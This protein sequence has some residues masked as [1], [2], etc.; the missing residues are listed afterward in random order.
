M[1]RSNIILVTLKQQH[2]IMKSAISIDIT[3]D[4]VLAIVKSLPAR[5]KMKISKEL[6]K[7]GIK[8]KLTSILSSFR[9]DEL[10]IDDITQEVEH[11]R[12]RRY[13]GKKH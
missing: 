4:Q 13:E 5:Q 11:V 2:E 7:E 9:T 12:Q 8:T 3:F 1:F 10:S 6:E